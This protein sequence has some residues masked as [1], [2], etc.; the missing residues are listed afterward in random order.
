MAMNRGKQWE[1]KFKQDWATTWKKAHQDHFLFR[2][3]DQTSGYLTTS[4][5]PCD[6]I[7]YT[8]GKLFL[9]E[10]KSVE[11]NT[12]NFSAVR[13]YE[14][15]LKYKGLEGVFPGI[16]IWYRDHDKVIWVPIEEAEKLKLGGAKSINIKI[17]KDPNYKVLEIPSVK[18]RVFCDSDYSVMMNL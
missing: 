9:I 7:G 4:Q 10:C 8:K 14:R 15:L 18:K 16:L 11:G 3:P 13:Q 2:I 5:N 1:A 6:F 17:L 12:L